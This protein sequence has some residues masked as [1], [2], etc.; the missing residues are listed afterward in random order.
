MEKYKSKFKNDSKSKEITNHI[1]LVS[2]WFLGKVTNQKSFFI[3]EQL[4]PFI[5][6]F[7]ILICHFAF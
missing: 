7:C 6:S 1:L 3:C 2:S 5:F 4:R